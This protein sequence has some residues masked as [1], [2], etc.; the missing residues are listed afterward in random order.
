MKGQLR[1]GVEMTWS[2]GRGGSHPPL[3]QNPP[4]V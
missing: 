4:Q 2:V 3:T 1:L